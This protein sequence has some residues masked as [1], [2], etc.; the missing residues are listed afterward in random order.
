[1]TTNVDPSA[2]NRQPLTRQM[3]GIQAGDPG[4]GRRHLKH[5][6]AKLPLS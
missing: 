5:Q 2:A 1:M 6:G 4:G 3:C